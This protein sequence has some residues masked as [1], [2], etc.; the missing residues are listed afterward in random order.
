MNHILG[1]LSKNFS[2][3]SRSQIFSP[4]LFHLQIMSDTSQPSK[5][6]RVPGF[7]VPHHLSGFAQ[8]HGHGAGDNYLTLCMCLSTSQNLKN[9]PNHHVIATDNI[10][11]W[12]LILESFQDKCYKRS[13]LNLK[14]VL[15]CLGALD[16]HYIKGLCILVSEHTIY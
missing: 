8:T 13:Q 4:M 9:L 12:P 7:P 14:T 16:I 6:C 15:K 1:I 5:D 3:S 11:F 10:I 2:L